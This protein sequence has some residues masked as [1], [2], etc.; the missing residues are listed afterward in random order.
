VLSGEIATLLMFICISIYNF[1]ICLFL[2]RFS[3]NSIWFAGFFI[4]IIVWAVLI[5]NLKSSGGF[6][7]RWYGWVT[8][9][10]SAF[11]GSFVG[12]VLSRRSKGEKI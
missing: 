1:I 11:V 2:G 4:N 10:V 5:G 9:V 3:P 8:L 12:S 6:F 7:D